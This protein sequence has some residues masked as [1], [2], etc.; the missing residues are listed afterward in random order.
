MEEI[1]DASVDIATVGEVAIDFDIFF[2]IDY[3]G[4]TGLDSVFGDRDIIRAMIIENVITDIIIYLRV[5]EW[6][7]IS[8]NVRNIGIFKEVFREEVLAILT[9]TMASGGGLTERSNGWIIGKGEWYAPGVSEAV[10][11]ATLWLGEGGTTSHALD[12]G[13]TDHAELAP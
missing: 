8:F 9:N 4:G 5:I 10:L 1:V 12:T 13:I 2:G 6:R 3:L 11:F 7:F